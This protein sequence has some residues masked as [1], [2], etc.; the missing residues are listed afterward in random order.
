[1]ARWS[2]RGSESVMEGSEG[3]AGSEMPSPVSDT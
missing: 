2:S 3:E 1:M